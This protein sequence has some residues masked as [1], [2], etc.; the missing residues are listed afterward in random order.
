MPP[1]VLRAW[2]SLHEWCDGGPTPDREEIREAFWAL[3]RD[4]EDMTYPE[5]AAL[6]YDLVFIQHQAAHALDLIKET[7]IPEA[8]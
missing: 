2:S 6:S 8:G 5:R 7:E 1:I 3:L 4:M